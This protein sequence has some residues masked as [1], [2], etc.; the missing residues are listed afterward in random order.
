MRCGGVWR[1]RRGSRGSA[2]RARA[3]AL[4]PHPS[5][6]ARPADAPRPHPLPR[7][8]PPRAVA[9]RAF[10]ARGPSRALLP[11]PTAEC[12]ASPSAPNLSHADRSAG[13]PS[14]TPPPGPA[15]AVRARAAMDG[16][17]AGFAGAR[18]DHDWRFLQCFGERTP[19]EEI[20]DG[21]SRRRD[22]AA[23]GAGGCRRGVAPGRPAALPARAGSEDGAAEKAAERL[24]P[25]APC[26]RG[27]RRGSLEFGAPPAGRAA[28]L[29]PRRRPCACRQTRCARGGRRGG[30][31]EAA[32]PARATARR[33][34]P[35]PSFP[36]SPPLPSFSRH[37]LRRRVR[38]RRLP[39]GHRRPR[40]PR[41]PV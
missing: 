24:A 33:P 3:P 1:F 28:P 31:W 7:R 17:A 27:L 29:P 20:Q 19:G 10:P 12:R 9:A 41:R 5:R 18:P 36:P 13:A 22:G 23:P 35:T 15:R 11:L 37:H 38:R 32:W 14:A 4:A 2:A 26:A 39:P 30:H 34:R 8:G 40:R 16:A 6:A 21:E 25:R